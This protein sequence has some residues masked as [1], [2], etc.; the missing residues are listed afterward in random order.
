[1]ARG[2]LGRSAIN[3]GGAWQGLFSTGMVARRRRARKSAEN[4]IQVEKSGLRY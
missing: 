2:H 1:L 3:V 4:K